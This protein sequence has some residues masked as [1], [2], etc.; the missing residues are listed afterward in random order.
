MIHTVTITTAQAQLLKQRIDAM[1][2]AHQQTSDMLSILSA[3]HVPPG[4]T[5]VSVNPETG[6]LLLQSAD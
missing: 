5:F 6:E 1:H 4:A 2:H 3:G